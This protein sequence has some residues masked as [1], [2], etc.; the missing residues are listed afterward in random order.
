MRHKFVA[1]VLHGIVSPA[2][3]VALFS[4]FKLMFLRDANIGCVAAMS[5]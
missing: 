3:N 4:M 5:G 2:V 1:W